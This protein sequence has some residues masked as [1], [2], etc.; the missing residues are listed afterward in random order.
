MSDGSC[1]V[2]DS[3]FKQLLDR[4]NGSHRPPLPFAFP[5]KLSALMIANTNE[6]QLAHN[7]L[8]FKKLTDLAGGEGVVHTPDGPLSISSVQAMVRK[9]AETEFVSYQGTLRCGCLSSKITLSP[10]PLVCSTVLWFYLCYAS[11][12]SKS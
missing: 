11:V 2:T 7:L 10:H 9:M 4:N 1:G 6:P 12:I 8:L 5:G 3:T